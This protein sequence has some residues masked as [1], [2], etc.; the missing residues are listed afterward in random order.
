MAHRVHTSSDVVTAAP[1]SLTRTSTRPTTACAC[2]PTRLSRSRTAALLSRAGPAVVQPRPTWP[3]GAATFGSR[4]ASPPTSGYRRAAA[5]P[6]LLLHDD[7]GSESRGLPVANERATD[8]GK[9]LSLRDVAVAQ[10]HLRN[11]AAGSRKRTREPPCATTSRRTTD[12]RRLDWPFREPTLR[13]DP[14]S[15]LKV[16][17]TA[18]AGSD[19]TPLG[20]AAPLPQ[21]RRER[22]SLVALLLV[23]G[24]KHHTSSRAAQPVRV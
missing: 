22:T 13:T 3:D 23:A 18:T 1:I 21:V 7:R 8:K 15:R 11:P 12:S 17:A 2:R 16:Y 9:R 10:S 4:H 19:S 5:A 24:Q 20:N 14:A 6:T